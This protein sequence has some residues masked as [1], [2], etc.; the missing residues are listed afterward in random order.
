MIP[1]RGPGKKQGEAVYEG[2]GLTAAIRLVLILPWFSH[3][4]SLC[5]LNI[6][7]SFICPRNF[8]LQG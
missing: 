6:R 4:V 7:R 8:L 5:M 1:G 3:R 2:T